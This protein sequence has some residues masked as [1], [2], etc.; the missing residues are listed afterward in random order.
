MTIVRASVFA[1]SD[2][3]NIIWYT[4]GMSKEDNKSIQPPSDYAP[5]LTQPVNLSICPW[6]TGKNDFWDWADNWLTVRTTEEAIKL[7]KE[8][9]IE[10]LGVG[11]DVRVDGELKKLLDEK[12]IH[13]SET[14]PGI[15]D[16]I[17]DW[18]R[19]DLTQ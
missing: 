5:D 10:V 7:L 15:E 17:A 2:A 16:D 4:A 9:K 12:G 6:S 14:T 8:G 18:F 1:R 11:S 13:Y 3:L 19:S